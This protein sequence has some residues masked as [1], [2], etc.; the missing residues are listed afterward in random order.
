MLRGR[1]RGELA[2]QCSVYGYVCVC[3][4]ERERKRERVCVC[5]C[6]RVCHRDEA[7]RVYGVS[8]FVSC[9]GMRC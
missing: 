3:V 9:H 6:V 2:L 1:S 5:V 4:C 7:W 8:I